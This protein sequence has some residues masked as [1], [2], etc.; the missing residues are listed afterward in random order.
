MYILVNYTKDWGITEVGRFDTWQDAA[1]EIAKGI[2]NVFE[3]EV[4]IDEFL[5]LERDYDNGDFRMNEK[6]SRIWFDNY[7]C[8]CESDSHKEE[9]LIL[10]V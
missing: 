10:P 3:V 8:Y 7:T 4:D 5:S 6:G 9:W 2:R 1:R